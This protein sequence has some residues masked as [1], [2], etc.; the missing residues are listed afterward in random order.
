[1]C[2]PH[3]RTAVQGTIQAWADEDSAAPSVMWLYGPAGAGKSAI[4]QTMAER[5]APM[6]AGAKI[7]CC[8]F[9]ARWR[10]GGSS[11]KSLFPTI[12]YQ[13]ARHIP[14]IRGSIGLAVEGNP[15]ICERTRL[16]VN[17]YSGDGVVPYA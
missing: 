14:G 3:T 15:A 5:W 7:W 8:F 1:Q 16:K 13:F 10:V 9:F 6:A 4:A 2:H 11:G 17:H 12:A